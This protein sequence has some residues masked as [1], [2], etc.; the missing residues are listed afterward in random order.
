MPNEDF[1]SER[2]P[3]QPPPTGC[4]DCD[5]ECQ[6]EEPIAY[7]NSQIILSATDIAWSGLGF[8]WSHTR[9]YANILGGGYATFGNGTP[10]VSQ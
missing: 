7:G 9:S 4:N 8:S 3:E 1:S 5:P 6:S 2:T 10:L